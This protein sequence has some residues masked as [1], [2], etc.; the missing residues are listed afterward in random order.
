MSPPKWRGAI[1][2]P[3]FRESGFPESGARNQSCTAL[4]EVLQSPELQI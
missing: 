2:H 4:L 3:S 1:R